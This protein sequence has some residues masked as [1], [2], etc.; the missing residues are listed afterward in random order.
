VLVIVRD[1]EVIEIRTSEDEE[2]GKRRRN[3]GGAA[4]IGQLDRTLPY[5]H[6]NVIVGQQGLI[7][8]QRSSFGVVG[9]TSPE[10]EPY[11]RTPGSLAT[12]QQHIDAIAL[13]WVASPPKLVDP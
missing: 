13:G 9:D 6:G 4:A 2:V 8:T 3:A 10:L 5:V 12:L 7:P 1:L 11:H